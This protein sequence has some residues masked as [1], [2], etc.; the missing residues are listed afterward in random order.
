MSLTNDKVDNNVNGEPRRVDVDG[1]DRE[2]IDHL[3]KTMMTSTM[4]S[5]EEEAR[6]QR[7]EMAKQKREAAQDMQVMRMENI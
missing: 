2:I 7:E 4:K 1:D 6:R 3:Q 5:R